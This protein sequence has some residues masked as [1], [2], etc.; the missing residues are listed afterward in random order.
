MCFSYWRTTYSGRGWESLLKKQALLPLEDIVCMVDDAFALADAKLVPSS[1][2]LRIVSAVA[3]RAN[4]P[5]WVTA[6]GHLRAWS[7]LLATAPPPNAIQALVARVMPQV[8]H[9]SCTAFVFLPDCD[10]TAPRSS[11]GHLI[12]QAL[13]SPPPPSLLLAL[14]ASPLLLLPSPSTVPPLSAVMQPIAC[15]PQSFSLQSNRALLLQSA[16]AQ[17]FLRVH[18]RSRHTAALCPKA[19]AS[20][21]RMCVPPRCRLV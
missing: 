4:Y 10:L 9:V 13:Q 5:V 6:I 17:I 1:L 20:S 7:R 11:L 2:P 19:P 3:S 14:T 16:A 12:C 21:Q 8:V 15:K 18:T